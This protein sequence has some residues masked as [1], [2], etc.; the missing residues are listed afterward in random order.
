[1]E[2]NMDLNVVEE[3][4]DDKPVLNDEMLKNLVDETL[5]TVRNQAMILGYRVACHTIMDIISSWRQ[6][7]C[8]H[9]EY[10]RIFKRV[11][12]FCGKALNQTEKVTDEPAEV[13]A[14]N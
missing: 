6:P 11:E 10:E 7:N 13:T 14:Q 8:S 3:A 4:V 2:D 1:M 12:E 5:S 9:R